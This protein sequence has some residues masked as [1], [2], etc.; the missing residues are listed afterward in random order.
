RS[1]STFDPAALRRLA[2]FTNAQTVL[3]GQYLRFGN[4]IRIDATLED[5]RTQRAVPLKVE[6]P[7]QSG[8]FAAITQLAQQ[9]R[10]SLALSPDI[11]KELQVS[12]FR[13]SSQSLEALRSYHDGLQLARQGKHS[14]ALK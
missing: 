8:L 7:S 3:W 9:V 10:E 13:P 6:S 2:E 14:E 12:S 5:L 11:V 1:D 4:E